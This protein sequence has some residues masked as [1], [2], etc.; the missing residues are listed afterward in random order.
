MP[1][2][3]PRS[4]SSYEPIRRG[5]GPPPMEKAGIRPGNNIPDVILLGLLIVIAFAGVI[6][7][8]IITY[9]VK[10]I[11]EFFHMTFTWEI[12]VY[13]IIVVCFIVF[14]YITFKVIP[15]LKEK[16]G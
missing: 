10:P 12:L 4:Y 15:I 8:L 14:L 6:T 3:D 5:Y 16:Y 11:M 1:R 7:Y 13:P 2:I 9:L